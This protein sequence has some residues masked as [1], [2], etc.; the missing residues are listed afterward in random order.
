MNMKKNKRKIIYSRTK[1][2]EF[3]LGSDETQLI[4]V[5]NF[6]KWYSTSGKLFVATLL[7][8]CTCQHCSSHKTKRN[9]LCSE[10]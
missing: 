6:S 1:L 2:L 3:G 8:P 4:V 9:N 7:S 5:G 10:D